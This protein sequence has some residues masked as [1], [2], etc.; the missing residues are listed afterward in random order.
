MVFDEHELLEEKKEAVVSTYLYL[1]NDGIV[2][3]NVGEK[4]VRID[5]L[6]FLRRHLIF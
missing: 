3:S 6:F 5:C 4:K 1:S 2:Y